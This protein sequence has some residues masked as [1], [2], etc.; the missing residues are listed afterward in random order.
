MNDTIR[1]L[2]EHLTDNVSSK[3][4]VFR[5]PN[6]FRRKSVVFSYARGQDKESV[7][8]KAI[9]YTLKMNEALGPIPHL[10][11]EGRM[12]S[13]NRSGIVRVHPNRNI[14]PRNGLT[15]YS[16]VAHWKGCPQHGGVSWPCLTHTDEGA[17]V[18]AAVTLEMRTTSRPKVLEEYR[19]IVDTPKYKEILT[20]H[21][22]IPIEDYWPDQPLRDASDR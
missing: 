14:A 9:S 11:P 20:Q 17:F 2:P 6:L 8:K 19:K 10:S 16:W 1:E 21:P 7:K 18:L 5:H 4:Y 3:N 13:R 12:S 15:Y 22:K